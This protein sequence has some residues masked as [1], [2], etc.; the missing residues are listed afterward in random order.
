MK[1]LCFRRVNPSPLQ[2]DL[3]VRMVRFAAPWFLLQR[4]VL[5]S[6]LKAIRLN[7]FSAFYYY[8]SGEKNSSSRRQRVLAFFPS[9]P[10]S[11]RRPPTGRRR[12]FLVKVCYPCHKRIGNC[13]NPFS[14][15]G[16]K[17]NHRAGRIWDRWSFPRFKR[18]VLVCS[19]FWL[20]AVL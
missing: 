6:F 19:I 8:T 2:N 13:L 3:N 17:P 12:F 11:L 9:S 16:P 14:A 4:F 5:I 18:S 1:R 15:V 7:G 10:S 20:D